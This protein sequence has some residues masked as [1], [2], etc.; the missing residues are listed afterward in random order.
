MF[1]IICDAAAPLTAHSER[2]CCIRV[3][4]GLSH[5][6]PEGS[7]LIFSDTNLA[8]ATDNCILIGTSSVSMDLSFIVDFS[9]GYEHEHGFLCS[10]LYPVGRLNFAVTPPTWKL[11]HARTV[12]V[13]DASF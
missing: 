8:L 1:N 10:G 2:N 7:C 3:A 6:L 11:V 13:L 5:I 9:F 4:A 12:R